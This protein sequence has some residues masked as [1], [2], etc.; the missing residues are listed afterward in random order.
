M[1]LPAFIANL[2]GLGSATQVDDSGD[3]QRMQVTERAAGNGFADRVTDKVP[4]IGE[5]GFSSNPPLDCEVIVIRRA[6]DRG[7]P[8]VIATS[9]RA[10][11][12]KNLQPGEVIVYGNFG[13]FIKFTAAGP[14]ID[15]GGQP[16]RVQNGDV[17]V[18]GDV[19][20]RCDGTSVSLNGLRDA[21]DAHKHTGVSTGTGVSGVS[22]HPV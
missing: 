2:L 10:S 17:H 4:R 16:V 21:Y 18:V 9:H 14:V 3:L 13:G 11:R 20:S 22:D 5:Y 12:P 7:Q 1:R 19:V 15:G 6:G 8:I